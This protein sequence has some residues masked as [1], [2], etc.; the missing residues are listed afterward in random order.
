MERADRNF[1]ELLQELR[2]TQTGVQMLFAFLLTLAFSAR[3][4]ELD[5]A[6]RVMYV[7]TLLLALVATVMFT[8]PA[9]MHRQLFGLGAKR[10]IVDTSSRLAG[11]GLAALGLSLTGALLLVV[12]VVF[13][14]AAGIAVG[15][16]AFLLCLVTWVGLPQHLRRK[17]GPGPYATQ[18]AD[19]ESGG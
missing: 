3:F 16:T 11:A 1:A 2:V 4:P 13:G 5:T 6:Q 10:T 8:A 9:A 7:T 19:G 17:A 12:D 18:G 15:S 14:R